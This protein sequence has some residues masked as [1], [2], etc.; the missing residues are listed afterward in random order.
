[1]SV[2]ILAR[3]PGLCVWRVAATPSLGSDDVRHRNVP[4]SRCVELLG[5]DGGAARGRAVGGEGQPH[6]RDDQH[7]ELQHHQPGRL[8]A[9]VG[10]RAKQDHRLPLL[11]VAEW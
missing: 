11:R 8:A 2:V 7:A 6:E 4:A 1:M 5:R 3:G 10:G 9:R